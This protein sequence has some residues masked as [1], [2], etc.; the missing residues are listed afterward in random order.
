MCAACSQAFPRKHLLEQADEVGVRT[1]KRDGTRRKRK[2][3]AATTKG[4]G[5]RKKT[6]SEAVWDSRWARFLQIRS[7]LDLGERPSYLYWATCVYRGNARPGHHPET[8]A[9]VK[10]GVGIALSDYNRGAGLTGVRFHMFLM[11]FRFPA[12]SAGSLARF[13][14]ASAR[15]ELALHVRGHQTEP[16]PFP[17]PLLCGLFSGARKANEAA[18]RH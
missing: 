8:C 15:K 6:G 14:H 11:R 7:T 17:E 5:R 1:A 10:P 12:C 3:T 9:K 2:K 18:G 13:S 16:R 4:T